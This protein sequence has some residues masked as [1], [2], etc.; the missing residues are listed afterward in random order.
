MN[1]QCKQGFTRIGRRF[2]HWAVASAFMVAI[3]WAGLIVNAPVQAANKT[4]TVEAGSDQIL[5]G[6]LGRGQA[7]EPTP[8]LASLSSSPRVLRLTLDEAMALFLT[9]NLDLIIANYGIDAAKG[10]QITA[11]LFPNPTLSV[12]TFSAYT[13]G[14]NLH[15]CGP[16]SDT[17]ATVRGRRET[18][19]QDGGCR[20]GH[21]VHRS[22]V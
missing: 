19:V 1:V 13:Q 20:A 14:C 2:L 21:H 8:T 6:M 17:H 5:K 22:E 12:N 10:R 3:A 16:G 9:Q 4:E 7:P 11:R 15:K 18:R